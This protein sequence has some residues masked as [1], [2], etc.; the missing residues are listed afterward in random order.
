MATIARANEWMNTSGETAPV[1]VHRMPFS[2]YPHFEALSHD[3]TTDVCVVGSGIAGISTAYELITRGKRVTMIDARN[4]L[5]GESGRTSGHLS[6]ALDDGYREI[7]KK[8]GW[9]GAT[10]AADSHTWAIDRAADIVKKL[11]LD[12]EFRYLPAIKISQYPR[13][14]PKHD[15]EV[16]MIRDEVDCATKAG[17][18]VSF[19]EGLTVQGWDGEIDQ[20]DGA[21]FL[22][23]ATFHPTK[24]M[25]GLLEWLMKHPNFQCFTHTRMASIEEND[26]V[27]VRTANGNSITASDIVE[28]TCIPIQKLSIVAELEY[29]RTYCIA[30]R[31]PKDYIEDCLIYDQAK[32]YKYV[33]FT[34]C[35][36]NEDYLVIGGCDHKVGQDQVE[37]R[38]Q[39]LETWVRQRFTRA[40][41]VDY[42][43]SGQIFEPVDY[44]AFI[45]KNQGMNHTYVVTGDSGNGLTHGILAGKLIADEIEGVENP[46]A[47]LYDPKRLASIAEST[48]S[49]LKH[50]MQINSQYKRYL[51]SDIKDIEDLAVGS[52]GVV[53]KASTGGPIAVYKDEG[54]QAHR[55]SAICPHMK[56]VLSWNAAEKSWDCPVHGSRFSCDGVCVQGPANSN[57]KP[58]DGFSK[59]KQ[60]EQEVL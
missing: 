16:G 6:N 7:A 59:S 42:K 4:V 29:M 39:E 41:S 30:I 14:D 20:R 60:Q 21:L 44:M 32:A 47:S 17:I 22:G 40:G 36:E 56:A 55:F 33:R 28:T 50:D 45:G 1:W 24:Y 27:R 13:E 34:S 38:F 51:H 19:R 58:L 9:K 23:Q 3:T 53:N 12:C 26:H 8:H 52:G 57:L 10:V 46:W 49:M 43:W 54:G 2:E 18:T 37:G 5:S 11:N 35:D 48:G 15:E 31:V 25:A